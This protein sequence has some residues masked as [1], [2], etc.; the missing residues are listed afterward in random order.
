MKIT[1][2]YNIQKTTTT[3]AAAATVAIIITNLFTISFD[4]MQS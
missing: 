2:G 1:C 4:S 3:T